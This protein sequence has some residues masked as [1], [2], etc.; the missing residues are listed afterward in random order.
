M[1]RDE[2]KSP[3][4]TDPRATQPPAPYLSPRMNPHEATEY[5]RKL[6]QYSRNL[7]QYSSKYAISIEN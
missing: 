4:L 3:G 2:N 5:S 6:G 7:G 1:V